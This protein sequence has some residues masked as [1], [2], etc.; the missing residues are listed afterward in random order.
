[1]LHAKSAKLAG[2]LG[3]SQ[4]NGQAWIH[5]C[6]VKQTMMSVSRGNVGSHDE[7]PTIC[8]S[9]ST[10]KQGSVVPYTVVDTPQA[11]YAKDYKDRTDWITYL[12]NDHVSELEAAISA[13]LKSGEVEV[14]G[15]YVQ[16]V[17]NYTVVREQSGRTVQ[18][19]ETI[20]TWGYNSSMQKK[21]FTKEDFPLPSLAPILAS[22]AHEVNQGRGFALMKG[23][24]VQRWSRLETILAY[25]GIGLHWGKARPQNKKA[26]II[27]TH[28]VCL[29]GMHNHASMACG[30][31]PMQASVLPHYGMMAW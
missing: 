8:R 31:Q 7:M 24:P 28:F 1:M 2:I 18:H 6:P 21:K 22:V 19:G 20:D 4:R 25:W 10:S 15:N 5:G 12:S 17:S 9:Y 14:E 13:L 27:G 16:L 3:T 30:V 26:H 23:F 29:H 11:W